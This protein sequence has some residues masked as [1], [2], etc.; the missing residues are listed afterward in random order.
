MTTE[1]KFSVL[2]VILLG[3]LLKVESV[4]ELDERERD[5]ELLDLQSDLIRPIEV[6]QRAENDPKNHRVKSIKTKLPVDGGLCLH[7]HNRYRALHHQTPPLKWSRTLAKNA[8]AWANKMAR[9]LHWRHPK[10]LG[11]QGE[12]LA[13]LRMNLQ[14]KKKITCDD[15]RTSIHA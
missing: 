10:R 6:K 7:L 11:T 8:Q 9:E 3:L 14:S 12:N 15:L 1:S 4:K 2:T 13:L 5:S